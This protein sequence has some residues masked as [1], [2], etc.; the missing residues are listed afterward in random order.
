MSRHSDNLKRLCIK[1][2]RY[3]AQDDP[4]L[5]QVQSELF[6]LETQQPKLVQRQDYTT[7]YHLFIK[8]TS[9]TACHRI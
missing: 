7:S 8:N 4:L 2:Q 3:V 9:A 1:L 5:Q 6:L